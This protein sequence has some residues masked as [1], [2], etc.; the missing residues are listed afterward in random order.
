MT[1]LTK[2]EA[3]NAAR[4]ALKAAYEAYEDACDA[5]DATYEAAEAAAYEVAIKV[6]GEAD[7]IYKTELDRINK[8]Y[9]QGVQTLTRGEA[10]SAV[11]ARQ[12]LAALNNKQW[13][14]LFGGPLQGFTYH[15]PFDTSDEACE[16]G[17]LHPVAADEYW[18]AP[19]KFSASD[20]EG[21]GKWGCR[22]CYP[23]DEATERL[24]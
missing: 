18:V 8:E 9:P 14:V 19:L 21:C 10:L 17:D 15:G 22:D 11:V 6:C 16:Y 5:A 20:D 4:A 24:T 23:D 2:S 13:I 1:K 3:I 12:E 7:A